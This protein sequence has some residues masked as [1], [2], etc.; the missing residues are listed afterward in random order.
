MGELEGQKGYVL[1]VRDVFCIH[2]IMISNT[3]SEIRMVEEKCMLCRLS[4][5]ESHTQ[6]GNPSDGCHIS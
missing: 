6:Q 2:Q 5:V 4:W 3:T 1:S